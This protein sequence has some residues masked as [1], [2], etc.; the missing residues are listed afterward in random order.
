MERPG[1]SRA[2]G[3]LLFCLKKVDKDVFKN[4]GLEYIAECLVDLKELKEQQT[5]VKV[6]RTTE[7]AVHKVKTAVN[8]VDTDSPTPFI[9]G[10][11]SQSLVPSLPFGLSVGLFWTLFATVVSA[12]FFLGFF[13]G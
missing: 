5:G 9:E 10:K 2:P 4:K 7:T 11:E 13:L 6:N 8:L 12:S 1:Y 3:R